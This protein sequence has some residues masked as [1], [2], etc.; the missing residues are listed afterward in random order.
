MDTEVLAFLNKCKLVAKTEDSLE[1][2]LIPRDILLDN[3]VYE[4]VKEDIVILK[5]KFSIV[6]V[7]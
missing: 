2:M 1:G 3:T 5:K 7:I 4:S 6:L